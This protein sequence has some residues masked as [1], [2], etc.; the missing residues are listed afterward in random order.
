LLPSPAWTRALLAP[1]LVFIA[2]AVDRNYQTDFWHHLARGRA[3]AAEGG[4]VDRDLFTYTVA[5]RP[6]QDTNWLTQLFYYFLYEHGGLALV[7]VVN[8]LT[9]AVVIGVV[10][11]MCRRRCPSLLV[12]GA[13]GVF[14]FFGLW[15]L[16]IIRPQT[17]SLLLFVLMYAALDAAERRP[18][19][20]AVPP[21]LMALWVNLHGGFP[22]GLALT[23]CFFLAAA[24]DGWRRGGWG[25]L[26]DRRVWALGLC[27]AAAAL[28]TL[29]NPYGWK[30]YLYVRTTSLTSTARRIDEW[31]PPGL[32]LLVGKVWVLS[33]LLLLV[34]FALPRRRPTAR[35]VI[36]VLCFLPA[37]CGSVRMVAW[38]LLVSA[39]VIAALL[40]DNLPRHALAPGEDEP[41]SLASAGFFALLL[42]ACVGSAL[43][44][45]DGGAPLLGT[46][47][48][49]HRD[50]TDL[51]AVAGTLPDRTG[52]RV[53]SRFEWGE[54][55]GWSLEPRGYTVFMD[56]RIEIFPD[57]VWNQYSAITR[58]RADWEEI[59]DRYQVDTLL[60]DSTYH[61]D[62]LPQVERSPDWKRAGEAGKAVLYLRCPHTARAT[63]DDTAGRVAARR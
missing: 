22:I 56:G 55:L 42:L 20:L 7:Q 30:V 13:L 18:W 24:W 35:E 4:L 41:P 28:A 8:S 11:W 44:L 33:V 21:L 38:W 9:L 47:R 50:E 57:E 32:D 19:L 52:G 59:L 10:V 25:V 15:Q 60:L 61:T 16:L 2:T 26:R 51:E 36:L 1:A 6:F 40:A 43:A 12:A 31:V 45:T 27:L 34:L 29:A 63:G 5:G 39:P 46:I 48:P 53:F 49:T 23:G 17:F 3:M 54:Y 37:A 58:G 14:T 62:L